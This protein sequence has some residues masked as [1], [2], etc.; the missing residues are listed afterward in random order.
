MI[1][2]PII[3]QALRL[4]AKEGADPLQDSFA[5]IAPVI[6]RRAGKAAAVIGAAMLADRFVAEHGAFWFVQRESPLGVSLGFPDALLSFSPVRL[7]EAVLEQDDIGALD[8]RERELRES[9]GKHRSQQGT[10]KLSPALY[11]ELFDPE[12]VRFCVVDDARVHRAL[13]MS[14]GH[15]TRE[16]RSAIA[17]AVP[18]LARRAL[19]EAAWLAP[20]KNLDDSASLCG[21]IP[22]ASRAIERFVRMF[23][24]VSIGT[25]AAA[26]FWSANVFDGASLENGRIFGV[27]PR[28]TTRP[29]IDAVE[30]PRVY[31]VDAAQLQRRLEGGRAS[32][33]QWRA[34]LCRLSDRTGRLAFFRATGGDLAQEAAAPL[35]FTI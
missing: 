11:Q 6:Q 4:L 20:F 25:P 16:M 19:I 13:N 32:G 26:S 34:E 22:Q 2:P 27:F 28:E 7:V 29:L 1:H 35:K 15:A 31:L 8:A 30:V 18:D 23:A 21:Q 10:S 9:L 17:A 3:S 24:T 5:D 33:E 14:A 12:F